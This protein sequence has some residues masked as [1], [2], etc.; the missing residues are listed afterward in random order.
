M[1]KRII[2]IGLAISAV[3]LI[4][5]YAYVVRSL[6]A[7]DP[8]GAYKQAMR[9]DIY[10]GK[11][12][13]ET[14]RLFVAALRAGDVGLASN[15]FM[16]DENASREQWAERL[17]EIKDAN[18]LARMADD[19]EANARPSPPSYEGHA[20]F[21][22]LNDDGTLGALISMQFNPFSGVWKLQSF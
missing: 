16:L 8:L 4:G 11:T 3:L 21:E 14:L 19:I 18:F 20:G 15:Y 13:E 9:E 17:R 5:Y 10:G 2:I 6:T 22:L 1:H 12:P 7:N